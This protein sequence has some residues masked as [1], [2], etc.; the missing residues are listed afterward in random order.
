MLVGLSFE[1]EIRSVNILLKKLLN[2]V[3]GYVQCCNCHMFYRFLSALY[4]S[5]LHSETTSVLSFCYIPEIG[6]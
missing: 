4:R 2:I 5:D 3:S 1:V 6:Q